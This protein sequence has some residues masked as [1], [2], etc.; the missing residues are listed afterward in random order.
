MEWKVVKGWLRRF[1][2]YDQGA[3]CSF[4]LV[5]RHRWDGQVGMCGVKQFM[6][7]QP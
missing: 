5:G 2:T 1:N 3:R 7:T 4:V 6:N